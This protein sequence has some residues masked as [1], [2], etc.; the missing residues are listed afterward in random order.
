[1]TMQKSNLMMKRHETV[2]D[3]TVSSPFLS[4][5]LR[6]SSPRACDHVL[7]EK[8]QRCTHAAR[9]STAAA[10]PSTKAS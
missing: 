3:E 5:S 6:R 8:V 9:A 4:A 7:Q 1:M 2:F 10:V